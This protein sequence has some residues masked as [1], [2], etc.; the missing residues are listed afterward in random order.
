MPSGESPSS[1]NVP[2]LD[3]RYL[4]RSI[5]IRL[6]LNLLREMA[7]SVALYPATFAHYP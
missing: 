6:H 4:D 1:S 5:T 2:S 7:L 3:L